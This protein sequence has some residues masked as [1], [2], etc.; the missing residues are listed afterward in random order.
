MALAIFGDFGSWLRSR[1]IFRRFYSI[2]HGIIKVGSIF[3][4]F[5]R[6]LWYL[7]NQFSLHIRRNASANW[8]V[9]KY[10]SGEVYYYIFIANITVNVWSKCNFSIYTWYLHGAKIRPTIGD[11]IVDTLYT[12]RVTSE[13]KRI[14]A[15][16]LPPPH[17]KFG[18]SLFS[19][20]TS[21]IS[22]T[23]HWGDGGGK[24]RFPPFEVSK[25]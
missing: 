12:N 16:P 6:Y 21:N 22:T 25:M 23:L 1:Y 15:P 7:E 13:N 9:Y 10:C 14:R 8:I 24:A 3:V 20:G 18:C 11:K 19:I 5:R 4:Q 17:S 2:R